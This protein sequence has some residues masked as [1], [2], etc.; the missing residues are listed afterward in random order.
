MYGIDISNIQRNIDL[1]EGTYHFAICKATEGKTFVDKSV[2]GYIRVLTELNK[3]IGLYHYARPDINNTQDKIMKE[4]HHFIDTV[5]T[6]GMMGRAILVIDW[7]GS[8]TERKDLL[9]T[10]INVIR[11]ETGITP[12]V[13]ANTSVLSTI[14]NILSDLE[15]PIWGA[16]WDFGNGRFAG[17]SLPLE[18]LKRFK[19]EWKIWQYTSNG[20]YPGYAGRI[21]LDYSNLTPTDWKWYAGDRQEKLSDD[22]KWAIENGLFYG[23]ADGTYRPN[24]PLKRGAAASLMRRLY[25]LIKE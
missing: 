18:S 24:E 3:Y 10:L 23:Y 1:Y 25:D 5:K 21:D 11:N 19:P 14:N 4:G 6:L 8:G 20:K 13:Y 9:V 22:M 15:V 16:M 7:E 12:F 2:Q 17:E